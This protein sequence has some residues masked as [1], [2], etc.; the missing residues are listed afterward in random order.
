MWAR[1]EPRCWFLSSLGVRLDVA[2]DTLPTAMAAQMSVATNHGL[3][4]MVTTR[5]F[6]SLEVNSGVHP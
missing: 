3:S 6:W 2:F 1:P 5:T 4:S